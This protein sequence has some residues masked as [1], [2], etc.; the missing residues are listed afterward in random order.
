MGTIG[1]ASP[2]IFDNLL[3]HLTMGGVIPMGNSLKGIR[4]SAEKLVWYTLEVT[5]PKLVKLLK[6]AKATQEVAKKA[7]EAFEASAE[8]PARALVSPPKG[9]RAVFSLKFDKVTVAFATETE[10]KAAKVTGLVI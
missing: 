1:R 6:E 9:A 10:K 2:L 3:Q 8:A 7:K 5:S 4:M